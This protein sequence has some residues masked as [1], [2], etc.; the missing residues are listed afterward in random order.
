[1]NDL[2]IVSLFCA[3]LGIVGVAISAG[4]SPSYLT[5]EALAT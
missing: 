4:W 3:V 1:M 5:N 2:V